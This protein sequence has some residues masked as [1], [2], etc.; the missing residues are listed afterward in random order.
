MKNH[1]NAIHRN[2][3][4]VVIIINEKEYSFESDRTVSYQAHFD[5]IVKI[6]LSQQEVVTS[7]FVDDLF[8]YNFTYENDYAIYLAL[9]KAKVE[10]H[11]GL[12]YIFIEL[13]V[14]KVNNDNYI[15]VTDIP[16][17]R[18]L[19][20]RDEIKNTNNFYTEQEK[21]RN[22]LIHQ[23]QEVSHANVK[24]N[25]TYFDRKKKFRFLGR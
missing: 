15:S 23:F 12:Y 14:I 7:Q 9:K 20:N 19:L 13:S 4:E 25:E 6:I 1:L 21:L 22:E 3:Q 18:I 8:K 11:W 24:H 10:G 16:S 17:L 5:K 2:G